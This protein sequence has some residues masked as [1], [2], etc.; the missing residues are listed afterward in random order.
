MIKTLKAIFVSSALL[1]S[2]ASIFASTCGMN[3]A[4]TQAALSFEL[5]DGAPTTTMLGRLNKTIIERNDFIQGNELQTN[6]M[7]RISSDE[8]FAKEVAANTENLTTVT[9]SVTYVI[10]GL[11]FIAGIACLVI[12]KKQFALDPDGKDDESE[13]YSIVAMALAWVLAII[14]F[15]VPLGPLTIGGW[16]VGHVDIGSEK[17]AAFITRLSMI[18]TD[19]L[20][21]NSDEKTYSSVEKYNASKISVEYSKSESEDII[22]RMVK[23]YGV[24]SQTDKAYWGL[25]GRYGKLA[26]PKTYYH[27]TDNRIEMYRTPP[28]SGVVDYTGGIQIVPA[29]RLDYLDKNFKDLNFQQYVTDDISKLEG[30]LIAA[31]QALL[32]ELESN[33]EN[34]TSVDTMLNTITLISRKEML[35]KFYK[36]IIADGTLSS[37]HKQILQQSCY[38]GLGAED[39]KIYLEFLKGGNNVNGDP[40]CLH[41]TDMTNTSFEVMGQGSNATD[42][43]KGADRSKQE[44]W[45]AKQMELVRK[46]IDRRHEIISQIAAIRISVGIT[47]TSKHVS[48]LAASSHMGFM[49]AGTNH[50]WNVED[51]QLIIRSMFLSSGEEIIEKGNEN[52]YINYETLSKG[53]RKAFAE[54]NLKFGYY[55]TRMTNEIK[56]ARKNDTRTIT[57]DAILQNA[58]ETNQSYSELSSGFEKITTNPVNAYYSS[59]GLTGDCRDNTLGCQS[60]VTNVLRNTVDLGGNLIEVGA[61][62]ILYA[63]EVTLAAKF[64]DKV[65]SSKSSEKGGIRAKG[66]GLNVNSFT[67]IG[68][69]LGGWAGMLMTFTLLVGVFLGKLLPF[70]FNSPFF[71]AALLISMSQTILI[72][73]INFFAVWYCSP[74]PVKQYGVIT[75]R[76]LLILFLMFVAPSVLVFIKI[77]SFVIVSPAMYITVWLLYTAMPVTGLAEQML[78]LAVI[79]MTLMYVVASIGKLCWNLMSMLFKLV[80]LDDIWGDEPTKLNGKITAL[81]GKVIPAF[82]SLKD[83]YGSEARKGF[84]KFGRKK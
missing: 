63:A 65:T 15:V 55:M 38:D 35:F 42:L 41:P 66:K 5:C 18:V 79:S 11:L 52:N 71:M 31:R 32:K 76:L 24:M 60:P 44:A 51:K 34:S 62:G 4:G 23:V 37:I 6:Y 13:T 72:V 47:D 67:G 21:I 36:E 1:L 27:F 9:N 30:N 70:I 56:S 61:K 2:S 77:L 58:G 84:R 20:G 43:K 78:V 81:V 68:Q 26:D 82:Q 3:D 22:L 16:V 69:L 48:Q 64:V 46:T 10:Y 19:K 7:T 25:L 33:N 45:F 50:L 57:T 83:I 40:F 14:L 75:N 80:G 53:G 12:I 29:P 49:I 74:Q 17:A 39:S 28:S 73:V 54:S 59:L 8:E